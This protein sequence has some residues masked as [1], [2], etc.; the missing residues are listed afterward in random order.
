MEQG[1]TQTQE[2]PA[3]RID[4]NADGGLAELG[5]AGVLSETQKDVYVG[6]WSQNRQRKNPN[7][8]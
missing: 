5:G 1:G 8:K 3:F 6:G 7:F 4:R 2:S